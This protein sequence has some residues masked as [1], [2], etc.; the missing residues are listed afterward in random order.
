[1]FDGW[2]IWKKTTYQPKIPEI[3]GSSQ[4]MVFA[5]GASIILS[6]RA[7]RIPISEMLK[8]CASLVLWHDPD[9]CGVS[10]SCWNTRLLEL[11]WQTG[12]ATLLRVYL[13]LKSFDRRKCHDWVWQDD[14][15]TI[16]FVPNHIFCCLK[17]ETSTFLGPDFHLW[18]GMMLTPQ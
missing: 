9:F 1:M 10:I 16:R 17:P 13:Q 3:A 12:N 6:R 15:W 5:L 18:Q 11:V 14:D 4:V 7:H 8:Q 2:E